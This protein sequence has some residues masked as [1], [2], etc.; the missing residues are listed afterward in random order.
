MKMTRKKKRGFGVSLLILILIFI[1]NI[2]ISYTVDVKQ[3]L[4]INA[5]IDS[6][7]QVLGTEFS[8]VDLW[9][10]NFIKSE[11]GGSKKF[12]GIDYST[13]VTV[14]AKGENTQELDEFDPANHLLKYHITEGK[15]SIAKEASAIWSLV[16]LGLN[17]TKVVLEFKFVGKGWIG[18]LMSGKVRSGIMGTS[19]EIVEE[20]KYYMEKGKPH[21][22]NSNK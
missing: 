10:A 13:R 8:E 12:N 5:N 14:T 20:L 17:K 19:A 22:N 18:L 9:C 7:W 6:T 15:P 11:A 4:A 2:F 21:P 16:D 3:E 1:S